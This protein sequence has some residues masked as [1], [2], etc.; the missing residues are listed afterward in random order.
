MYCIYTQYNLLIIFIILVIYILHYKK[1]YVIFIYF[2]MD[3]VFSS[4]IKHNLLENYYHTIINT[5][6]W[7]ALSD[8]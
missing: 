7:P 6:I 4:E 8:N 2:R 5:I 1:N 3:G